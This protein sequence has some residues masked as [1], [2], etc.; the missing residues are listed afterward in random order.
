MTGCENFFFFSNFIHFLTHHLTH[1]FFCKIG[2]LWINYP[3]FT[4][5]H[6]AISLIHS[7]Y[8]AN[9]RFELNLGL[10]TSHSILVEFIHLHCIIRSL[11]CHFYHFCIHHFTQSYNLES[12]TNVLSLSFVPLG[13]TWFSHILYGVW[14]RLRWWIIICGLVWLMWFWSGWFVACMPCTWHAYN[15]FD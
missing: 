1:A 6:L 12:L 5:F 8:L 9:L 13:V 2:W 11:G 4:T 15:V 14:D 7:K 10:S 3:H